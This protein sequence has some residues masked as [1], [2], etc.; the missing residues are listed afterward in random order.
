M[1]PMAIAMP[2]NDMMLLV[3]CIHHIGKNERMIAMGS[4]MIATSAER[5][6]QR[7]TRQT[8]AT[9]MLSSISFSRNVAIARLINSLRS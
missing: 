3:T 9:T 7:K 1:A 2:P 4:V 5:T 6:C 8:R